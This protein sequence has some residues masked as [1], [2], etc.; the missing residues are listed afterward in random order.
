MQTHP[1]EKPSFK[2]N[3]KAQYDVV[4]VGGGPAGLSA[5][6]AILQQGPLS[7]L[8]V[9]GQSPEQERIGESC[10][11]DI[12][13]R[14][15]Q[16]GLSKTFS[17]AQHARCPGYASVWG[18][19][20]VGYNDFIVNPLGPGW[21]LNRK[22][23]DNMLAQAALQQGAD[24][25]YGL[26]FVDAQADAQGYRLQLFNSLEKSSQH[27]QARFVI[28][29]T[30]SA[31]RF[32]KAI[33]VQAKIDD[34][35]FARVRFADV[36]EG[37][38][39][40]QVFLE[41]TANGWWY[42]AL[43]PENRLISMVV[44]DKETLPALGKNHHQGFDAAL[45]NTTFMSKALAD[46]SLGHTSFHT[47][48]LYSGLLP[49]LEG[50]NWMAIGDAASRYDPI[51]AHGIY[52]G[53]SDGIESAKKVVAFFNSDKEDKQDFSAQVKQRH[54]VYLQNRAQLYAREQRWRR[55][56]FWSNRHSNSLSAMAQAAS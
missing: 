43:L 3:I 42:S 22:K 5:A 20:H 16:L 52:K 23:F 4:I 35:L 17:E 38:V 11:P 25:T 10:P 46:L 24:V 36:E 39:S 40:K 34:Q 18:Q 33:G 37:Q 1:K 8:V 19:A 53:L 13:L 55:H 6:I 32:A 14:L 12:I 15:K 30:G 31:A 26:R 21:R 51:V 48:P 49:T 41:A 54:Q 28:D 47:W 45:A 50:K 56:R 7:L 44:T 27:T 9:E 29:A 2:V